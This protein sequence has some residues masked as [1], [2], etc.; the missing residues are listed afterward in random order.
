MNNL[1]LSKIISEIDVEV[2]FSKLGECIKW[3]DEKFGGAWSSSIKR[4]DLAL[5]EFLINQSPTFIK[6]ESELY[7]KSCVD[8]IAEFNRAH[9]T[10]EV[11]SFLSILTDQ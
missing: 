4:F 9:T 7:K 3:S 5:T 1:N 6:T 2:S 10:S 8:L 11:D